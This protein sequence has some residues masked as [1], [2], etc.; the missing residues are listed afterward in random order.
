[1][2][3]YRA[4][5]ATLVVTIACALA[6]VRVQ[7]A[8]APELQV[9][10]AFLFNLARF[11]N[12]PQDKV[13]DPSSP[14]TICV[15][16]EPDFASTVRDTIQGKSVGAHALTMHIP[17][18]ASELARCQI[19]Y[20]GEDTSLKEMLTAASGHHVLTVHSAATAQP[21]GVVRLYLD[22]RR[23]RFEVNTGAASREQLQLSSKLLSLAQLVNL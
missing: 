12:W 17:A 5:I 6:P 13:P 22:E 18:S 14:I 21:G 4:L 9:R 8:E 1:M 7:S 23:I 19:A 16:G 3:A 10:A 20:I 15:A 2:I 11:V